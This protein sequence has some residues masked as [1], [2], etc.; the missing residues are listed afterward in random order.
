MAIA[1]LPAFVFGPIQYRKRQPLRSL[2]AIGPVTD[3]VLGMS[4]HL[5]RLLRHFRGTVQHGHEG[6]EVSRRGDSPDRW[7]GLRANKAHRFR[8][9]RPSMWLPTIMLAWGGVMIGMGFVRSFEG[10]L[11]T[12]VFLGITEAGKSDAEYPSRSQRSDS[13]RARL[14]VFSLESPSS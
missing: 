14:Q 5:F 9:H 10:L 11:V 7:Q 4:R 13:H 3:A 6:M 8:C 1:A 12:R 2:E